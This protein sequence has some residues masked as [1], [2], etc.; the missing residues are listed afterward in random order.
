MLVKKLEKTPPAFSEPAASE[1][2]KKNRRAAGAPKGKIE[3]KMKKNGAPQARPR[4]IKEKMKKNG[5]PQARPREK[6]KKKRKNGKKREG[7][8]KKRKIT[9]ILFIFFALLSF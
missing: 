5:A 7:N 4:K 1:K 8:E 9:E 3:A 2:L 6:M